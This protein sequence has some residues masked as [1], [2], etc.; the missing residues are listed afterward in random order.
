[1]KS[2]QLAV[3][4]LVPL[5]IA[6]CRTDPAIPLLE[7]ENYRLEQEIHRLQWQIEDMQGAANSCPGQSTIRDRGSEERE[8]EPRAYRN[9]QESN[10]LKPPQTELG[11]PTN[12][13]PRSLNPDVTL[14]PGVPERPRASRV[15][16]GRD[17]AT[18]ARCWKEARTASPCTPVE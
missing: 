9:H 14:P 12:K 2:W 13:V 8:A 7:R 6:G 18:T 15:R 16:R 3:L 1:M 11:T 4:G 5:L 17:R 10:G